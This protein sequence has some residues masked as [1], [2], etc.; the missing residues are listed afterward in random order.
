MDEGESVAVRLTRLETDVGHIRGTVDR[1]P[2][3]LE[4]LAR[5]SQQI[6]DG[7]ASNRDLQ[8]QVGALDERLTVLERDSALCR[9][10]VSAWNRGGIALLSVVTTALLAAAGWL[11]DRYVR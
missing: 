1:V 11:V 5:V 3:A 10:T 7:M 4:N 9:S 8:V 6:A 2:P